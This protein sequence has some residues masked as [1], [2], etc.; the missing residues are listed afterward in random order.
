MSVCWI[1]TE[2]KHSTQWL[3]CRQT[4]VSKILYADM[5]FVCAGCLL[6]VLGRSLWSWRLLATS[7]TSLQ[8]LGDPIPWQVTFCVRGGS[9]HILSNTQI[10][11]VSWIPV[12]LLNLIF[13]NWCFY[14]LAGL[15]VQI[16][17]LYYCENIF[18]CNGISTGRCLCLQSNFP[19]SGFKS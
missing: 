3:M 14:Q 2:E 18:I 12:L 9:A 5:N 13:K 11:S 8:Q 6:N 7:R 15:V 1:P 10:R 17:Y 4:E 16:F 19:E